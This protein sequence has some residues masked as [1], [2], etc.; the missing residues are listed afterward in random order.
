[1][2]KE[3]I[4]QDSNNYWEQLKRMEKLIRAAGSKSGCD[5]FFSQFDPGSFCGSHGLP[6][7]DFCAKHSFFRARGHLDDLCGFIHILYCFKC[8]KPQI[9]TKYDTNVFFFQ[10]AVRSFDSVEDYSKTLMEIC[11]D[12]DKLCEQLSHQIHVESK[13]I[14]EKFKAVHNS[15]KYFGLSFVFIL[16]L[17]GLWIIRL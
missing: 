10:D 17:I 15:I 13:I 5:L 11:E 2:N 4:P 9:E 14:D 8:F 7:V 16:M 3:K 1:M 12:N 6:A